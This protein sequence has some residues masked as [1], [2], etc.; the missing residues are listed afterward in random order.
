MTEATPPSFEALFGTPPQV[1]VSA[2]GRVN[3]IGE[4]I[5]YTGGTV[6][7]TPIPSRTRLHFTPGGD[8]LHIH[9]NAFDETVIRSLEDPLEGHWSD[10]I[11]AGHRKAISIGIRQQCE[12]G[13]YQIVSD[14]PHG[15][16]VSSSAALLVAILRAHAKTTDQDI[17]PEHIARWAQQIEKDDIGVPVG[18]MD[19]MAIAAG[20]EGMAMALDT[21]SLAYELV[22][23]PEGFAFPVIHSGLTRTLT[24]GGYKARREA[25]EEAA[26]QLGLAD[27]EE[28]SLIDEQTMQK[29][30]GLPETICK[31]AR[32]VMTEHHR[33]LAAITALKASDMSAFGQLMNESHASMRDDFEIVPE[34][35]DQ[36]TKVAREYGALGS[37]LTGGGFGGC[38]VS[39]V[40][41][42]RLDRWLTDI[43]N[44][45]PSTWIVAA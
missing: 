19:Q 38:F 24:D 34:A 18:I 39:C 44:A 14:I 4:H 33:V 8:K 11:L 22:P 30:S 36:M 45:F 5:D 9:S 10:Y 7:P 29:L 6:L 21:K 42:D 35:M 25:C 23:L 37:R 12:G 2:P 28:L 1:T 27:L 3:L 20:V 17:T 26:R 41:R 40:P 16:G 13:T 31:R 15:A 32:H 43:Q